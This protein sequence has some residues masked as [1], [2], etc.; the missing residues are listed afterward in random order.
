MASRSRISHPSA[1][2]LA[3][4]TATLLVSALTACGLGP[5]SSQDSGPSEATDT[6][7]TRSTP[8]QTTAPTG[9]GTSTG[10]GTPR[11]IGTIATGLAVPWG[12]AF[13]PDGSAVV[14]ERDSRS[15]LRL[16]PSGN[17]EARVTELGQIEQAAPEVEAGLL[18]VAVSP[19]FEADRSLFFYATTA[20]D[21]SVFR[22]VLESDELGEPTPILT[23]IP[24]GAIHDGGRLEFGPDGFLYVSTG[25]TGEPG[26]AQDLSL[27]H[28]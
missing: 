17:G 16:D 19:D 22:V 15:V 21:N 4:L 10:T 5:E 27:I 7:S 1:V 18:G 2:R 20:E 12:I 11:V 24:K 26:L 14:T 28:I 13:L 8:P 6:P 23:G 25:E 3:A 9:K